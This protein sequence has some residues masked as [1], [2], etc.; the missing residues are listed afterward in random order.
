MDSGPTDKK[1]QTSQRESGA[2]EP[3]TETHSSKVASWSPTSFLNS[4]QTND[5]TFCSALIQLMAAA[6]A[7]RGVAFFTFRDEKLKQD[8]EQMYSLL[9]RED[10]RVGE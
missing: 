8:L 10:V 6:K 1:T 2:V 3:S 5:L 4:S 7:R 9:V